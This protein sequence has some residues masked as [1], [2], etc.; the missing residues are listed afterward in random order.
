MAVKPYEEEIG[1]L[2]DDRVCVW[3][4][5]YQRRYSWSPDIAHQ[6]I[7]DLA[8]VST[9]SEKH[10]IGASIYK[11]LPD[12]AKCDVGKTVPGH[13]CLELIDGQ[14]RLTTIRIWLL[15]LLHHG[16]ANGVTSLYK[17]NTVYL[18]SPN[19]K[20]FQYLEEKREGVFGRRDNISLVYC[21][22]R[23]LLWLGEESFL[24]PEHLKMPSANTSGS[25]TF[26]KWNTWVTRIEDR[27]GI[28]LR[29]SQP[30]TETYIRLTLERFELLLL[31]ITGEDD[32]V[33]I[34][35][36]LNG[37]R[38][39]L[40]QFD[41]LRN[42]IFAELGTHMSSTDRDT[43]YEEY[44][45]PA[46]RILES[47]PTGRGRSTD[48]NKN[49]FLYDYLISI[50]EG[51]Y[52]KFNASTSY[53]S[54]VKYMHNRLGKPRIKA[55]VEGLRDETT[56]WT[57]QKYNFSFN[58]DLPSGAHFGLKKRSRLML[59]RIRF[60]SEGPPAPLVE[61]ILRRHSLP[62]TDPR[63]FNSD[64]VQSSLLALEGHLFKT[65]LNGDSLTNFRAWTIKKMKEFE[66]KCFAKDGLPASAYFVSQISSQFIEKWQ[67][68]ANHLRDE[69]RQPY[70]KTGV[71]KSVY[72]LGA[73]RSL[74]L[75][76][77]V[78]EQLSGGSSES[79]LPLT[80]QTNVDD[81]F[82]VEHIFPQAESGEWNRDLRDWGIDKNLMLM[83]THSLGNLTALPSVEN[84]K[85]S[86]KSLSKKQARVIAA[87][88]SPE[89]HAV[90]PPVNDW[91]SDPIWTPPII[92]TRTE[93]FLELLGRR[94]G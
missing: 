42:L 48:S 24:E 5:H 26:E 62:S 37:N 31:K 89:I 3:I 71:P 69:V 27:D 53:L 59:P 56:L 82:W 32:P 65:L 14:Q 22:F 49:E 63:H 38:Q 41:H 81:A 25:T 80:L 39:E 73:R 6:L 12:E 68:V 70:V 72:G 91:L 23:Y 8:Q 67:N 61:F 79:L 78:C 51:A 77:A 74:A 75:L 86:N 17:L 94:W 93:K 40:S 28:H 76:D 83:R 57:I 1:F 2:L 11:E 60:A 46:E 15:A 58:A 9:S 43:F 54:F 50:G 45:A 87:R 33:R 18:Q 47:V 85:V 29:S 4:P 34:F 44:W 92:D 36:S 52:G 64:D 90:I 30:N 10:W 88:D 66:E 20:E 7:N 55:W 35:S 16:E 13:K 84:I 19:D 21:Y